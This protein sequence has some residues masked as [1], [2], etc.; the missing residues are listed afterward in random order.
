MLKKII[1]SIIGLICFSLLF[2]DIGN[3]ISERIIDALWPIG[4]VTVFAFWSFL[5]LRYQPTIKTASLNKQFILLTLFCFSLGITI[6]L[7]QPFF[8]RSRE[9]GDVFM[10]YV[11][12]LLSIFIVNRHRI[13]WGFKFAYISLFGY[14]LLPSALTLFDEAKLRYEFPV[15]ASFQQDIALTRWKSDQPLSLASPLSEGHDMM[16]ITFVPR[17]YSGVALRYFQGDWVSYKQLTIRFYNPNSAAL[18]VTLIMTDKHYNKGKP[19][20]Q[21]RFDK[22]LQVKPG[23]SQ[24]KIPLT[25][26][27]NGVALR[28]MDLSQMAG[29]DFYMY[30]LTG[31]VYLYLESVYLE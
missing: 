19:N 6:E 13:H 30:D 15:L 27:K 2:I 1:F 25:T 5:L 18:P 24:I 14:L 9:V 20:S 28:D 22:D 11:G 10:N 21:D 7:I 26:I 8:G 17:Q 4:H 29:V 3:L 31:P 23:L 16:K 12:V